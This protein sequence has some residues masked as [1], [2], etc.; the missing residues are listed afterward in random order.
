MAVQAQIYNTSG[1]N[2]GG[3]IRHIIHQDDVHVLT[4]SRNHVVAAVPL[5]IEGDAVMAVGRYLLN[6]KIAAVFY[7]LVA[8]VYQLKLVCAS[9][10][11][12]NCRD[13]GRVLNPV[14]NAQAQFIAGIVVCVQDRRIL[15]EILIRIFGEGKQ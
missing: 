10:A 13:T 1:N 6:D 3:I 14:F 7:Q 15:V 12:P 4:N 11:H 2:I 8:L 5:G 9:I